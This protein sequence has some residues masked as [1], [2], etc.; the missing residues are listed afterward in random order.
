MV[1]G[2]KMRQWE[3]S[4]LCQL[5]L[6]GLRCIIWGAWFP[7]PRTLLLRKNSSKKRTVWV[8]E[9]VACCKK[10]NLLGCFCCNIW[11]SSNSCKFRSMFNQSST[12]QL[13]I[14]DSQTIID[15]QKWLYIKPFTPCL[16]TKNGAKKNIWAS[17]LCRSRAPEGLP[18]RKDAFARCGWHKWEKGSSSLAIA[19]GGKTNPPAIDAK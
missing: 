4:K 16:P 3:R 15:H 18:P 5:G 7:H 19:S 9:T 10:A 6:L 2:E 13:V 14:C 12:I 1:R 11:H 17:Q 8:V